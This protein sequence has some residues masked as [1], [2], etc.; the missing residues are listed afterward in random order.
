M[1]HFAR[2]DKKTNYVLQVHV[3]N[4]ENVIDEKSGIEFLKNIHKNQSWIND[5]YFVQTSYNSK[6]RN[7][8]AGIGYTYNLELDAFIP[9]QPF[10]SWILNIK[11]YQWESPIIK[12]I[13]DKKYLWNEEILNWQE[14]K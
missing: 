14:F 7:E 6:I 2:I 1:S 12:P 5:I 10:K 8:F 13:D 3:V 11:S 4:N 9:P